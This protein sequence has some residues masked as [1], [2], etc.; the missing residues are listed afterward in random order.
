MDL[1]K[2]QM[3]KE[4]TGMLPQLDAD[5]LRSVHCNAAES[6]RRQE[7]KQ[8]AH[9]Y[10]ERTKDSRIFTSREQ[11]LSV[12]LD[13]WTGPGG[14]RLSSPQKAGEVVAVKGVSDG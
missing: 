8:Y 13:C 3:L 1:T 7:R 6:L 14:A 9:T 11:Q 5:D 12:R 10:Y 4:L 2:E